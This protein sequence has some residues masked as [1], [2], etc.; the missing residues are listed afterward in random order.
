[1]ADALRDSCA[2]LSI[3]VRNRAGEVLKAAI[4]AGDLAD[5]ERNLTA[6]WGQESL[7]GG[8]VRLF[9]PDSLYAMLESVSLAPIAERGVRV[10]ADYLPP[11][12]SRKAEYERIFELERKL[13][14]RSDFAAVAR[15][16][17]C[18]AHCVKC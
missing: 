16:T 5:A 15:Y 6:R 7:Y 4:Q 14:S 11:Q 17:H 9:S 18:L 13:G 1:V 8:K 10:L 2:I 12:V 3:L